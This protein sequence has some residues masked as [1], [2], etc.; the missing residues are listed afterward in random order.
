MKIMT[1]FLA[2]VF[3]SSLLAGTIQHYTCEA[4]VNADAINK[5]YETTGVQVN[6]I[7]FALKAKGFTSVNLY[8]GTIQA[9]MGHSLAES[10]LD[11]SIAFNLDNGGAT[12]RYDINEYMSVFGT[13]VGVH[14]VESLAVTGKKR[15]LQTTRSFSFQIGNE[16]IKQLPSCE[17]RSL[18]S[19]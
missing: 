8:H 1:S 19:I 4:Y 18:D 16:I 2:L 6:D 15:R 12:A 5:F 13:N 7:E 10:L 11:V 14:K 9:Q 17:L 3:S